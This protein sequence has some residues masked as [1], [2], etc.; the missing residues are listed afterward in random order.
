MSSSTFLE[1]NRRIEE[2]RRAK[3]RGTASIKLTALRF[4]ASSER[5][6]RNSAKG[7]VDCLKRMFQEERGCRQEDA[8]HHAIAIISQHHLDAALEAAGIPATRLLT[9]SLPY[10]ELELPPHVQLECLQGRDRILAADDVLVGLE[11][12]WVVNL[13]LHGMRSDFATEGDC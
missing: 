7:N 1:V 5:W 8:R 6:K 4:Q 9:D 13:F 12:R 11:K 2:E 10:P 3:Y